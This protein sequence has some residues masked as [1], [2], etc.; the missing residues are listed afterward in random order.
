[1]SNWNAGNGKRI[2]RGGSHRKRPPS[3]SFQERQWWRDEPEEGWWSSPDRAGAW[4]RPVV[5]RTSGLMHTEKPE[6]PAPAPPPRGRRQ[7]GFRIGDGRHGESATELLSSLPSQ[8]GRT[9]ES[10]R[11]LTTWDDRR[12]RGESGDVAETAG[13]FFLRPRGMIPAN[14]DPCFRSP[15]FSSDPFWWWWWW[16]KSA[17][18]AESLLLRRR[19][20][21][22]PMSPSSK[23]APPP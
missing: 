9:G 17:A 18:R 14:Q 23:P 8:E 7:G 4:C 15:P 21:W 16:P 19:L 3:A 2:C 6:T 5:G 11:L 1:M 20:I 12:R 10:P 13:S 22:N